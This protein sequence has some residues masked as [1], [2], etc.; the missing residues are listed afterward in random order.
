[1][2]SSATDDAGAIE[3]PS[4]RVLQ[5][6]RAEPERLVGVGF[7]CWLA[8]F[9]TGD[10][11]AWETA[12]NEFSRCLGREQAKEVV[13]DLAKFV[14]AV[15]ASAKRSIEVEPSGCPGFC[16]DE[17]LA[18]SIVAACQH[19]TR[20]ALCTAAAALVGSEDIGDTLIGAQKFASSLMKADKMLDKTSICQASCGLAF[21]GR[22][23]LQ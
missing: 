18:I 3:R 19:G 4:A 15:Q 7:R 16:R 21:R 8:G 9:Q 10:I 12:F 14:R 6:H 13:M 5:M 1:M 23:A 11:T 2:S 22:Q 20:S 17:C